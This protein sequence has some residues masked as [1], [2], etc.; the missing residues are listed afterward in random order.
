[1]AAEK[2][3]HRTVVVVDEDPES[4]LALDDF[5]GIETVVNQKN[6]GFW[7]SFNHV[8]TICPIAE[9]EPFCYFGKDVTFHERWLEEAEHCFT[10]S[11]PD[12]LGLL[13][14]RDDIHDGG[15]ASHGMTTRRWFEVV[16]GEPFF[17]SEYFHHFCDSEL[18]VRSRDLKRFTYCQAS[19]VPHH[20]EPTVSMDRKHEDKAVQDRR[21]IEWKGGGLK[22]ARE[23]MKSA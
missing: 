4:V 2:I 11:F 5:K 14:F 12:G 8:F 22:A 17:P 23:R 13:T 20:H 9:D 6:L 3:P 10:Q 21:Y 1:M 15:N 18:T 19:Y 7:Q 16:Y